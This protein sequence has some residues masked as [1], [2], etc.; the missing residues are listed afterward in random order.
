MRSA[1]AGV[2]GRQTTDRRPI[3]VVAALG[4]KP[5]K[6]VVQEACKRHRH[7]QSLGFC[8]RQANVLV[9]EGRSESRRPELAI[10]DEEAKD[11]MR[12]R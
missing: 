1:T 2:L 6:S 8:Q 5:Q 12:V 9:A 3:Q 10:G 11:L 4:E 7:T